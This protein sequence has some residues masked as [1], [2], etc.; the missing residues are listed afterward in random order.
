MEADDFDHAE[1]A[2]SV[3]EQTLHPPILSESERQAMRQF[4]LQSLR[5]KE[6]QSHFKDERKD[7][8]SKVKQDRAKLHE[9]MRA[10]GSK[11]FVMPRAIYKDAEQELSGGGLPAVPPYLRMQRNTSDAAITPAVAES[12]IMDLDDQSVLERI[13]SGVSPLDA[14]TKTIVDAARN[15]VRSV[16]E[17]VALS[18]SLEK[19]VKAMEV[20]EV[21]P[22]IARLMVDMHKAQQQTKAKSATQREATSDLNSTLKRLQPTVA[23]VLDKTGRNTQQVTL[24]GVQGNHR[25]VKRVSAR[26]PKV[27]LTLFEEAVTKVLRSVPID[28][29]SGATL[30]ASFR[31]VRK[32]VVKGVQLKLNAL[33]KKET[34]KVSLVSTK[35]AAEESEEEES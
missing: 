5:L 28:A 6:Q 10:Q 20:E 25:I 29:S 4:C 15:S 23:S 22:D 21:P 7:L 3:H 13:E 24:D 1:E 9:W 2:M 14:L 17:A 30:L 35:E 27:T 34:V 8:A 11:C 18:E 26:A 31:S 16:K 33:P 32:Q 19:G 12:A